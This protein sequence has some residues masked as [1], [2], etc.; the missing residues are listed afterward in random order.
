[1]ITDHG[2]KFVA[3]HSL[4]I[5]AQ[6]G[7]YLNE[8]ESAIDAINR[9]IEK[10]LHRLLRLGFRKDSIIIDPGIGFGK[11][12]YQSLSLIKSAKQ[13]RNL[14]CEVMFGHSRKSYISAF[15]KSPAEM[16]DLE[17]IA[18]SDYLS[19]CGVDYLRVHNVKDHQRFFVAKQFAG[20]G[21]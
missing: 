8:D 11:S 9:W 16:R 17:T 1:M 12:P 21:A 6:L 3:M 13:I 14:G 5:P 7:E 20:G 10:T 4:S 18:I 19:Q 2:C 15:H